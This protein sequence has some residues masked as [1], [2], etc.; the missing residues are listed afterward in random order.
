MS[1]EVLS[2][3]SEPVGAEPTPANVDNTEGQTAEKP[4]LNG[5]E[6]RIHTL[7]H[8]EKQAEQKAAQLE[9]ELNT[10]KATSTKSEPETAPEFPSNDLQYENPDE[11]KN[12]VDEYNRYVARQEFNRL[13]QQ[14]Q[15]EKQSQLAEEKRKEGLKKRDEIVSSYIENGLI[16]GVSEDK[17]AANEAVL[18]TVQLDVGLAE[19]LYSDEHGAKLVD[20]LA[21]NPDK[22]QSLASMNPY[23]AMVKIATEVKPAALSTK[24]QSTNAPDPM[25]P[26]IGGGTPPKNSIDSFLGDV[27]I[28]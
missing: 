13:N 12:K 4:K 14:Q 3:S 11:Y 10:L 20:Y 21:D 5:Y 24:P 22:L 15:E 26:T 19:R 25:S 18:K 8:R 28:K 9:A 7:V 17:M 6:K 27:V 2:G 1:D 23:D 16:H